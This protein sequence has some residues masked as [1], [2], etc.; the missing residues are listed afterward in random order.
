VNKQGPPYNVA[1]IQR[2]LKGEMSNGDMHR[3]E[4]EALNDPFLQDAIDGLR[5]AYTTHEPAAI[6]PLLQAVET[7]EPAAIKKKNDEAIIPIWRRK[8]V[9]YAVASAIILGS[10]W[11]I[12]NLTQPE[13]AITSVSKKV[14]PEMPTATADSAVAARPV[15]TQVPPLKKAEP[16]QVLTDANHNE[17]KPVTPKPPSFAL[18]RD[19]TKTTTTLSK[20]E[21][22]KEEAAA[23]YK[24][25]TDQALARKAET[26]A[27]PPAVSEKKS[28]PFSSV[29]TLQQKAEVALQDT[30]SKQSGTVISGKVVDPEKYPLE[31]VTLQVKGSS[32]GVVSDELGRFQM[33][34][35]DS[36]VTL[37]ASG[38]GYKTKEFKARRG[39]NKLEFELEPSKSSLSEAVVSDYSM[40]KS[41]S[42]TSNKI[43]LEIDTSEAA[44]SG[45]WKNFEN[46]VSQNKQVKS[47]GKQ[48]IAVILSFEVNEKGNPAEFDI[49]E[50]AG[51]LFDSEAIR[52]LKTGPLWINKTRGNS[53]MVKITILF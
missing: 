30:A 48:P 5:Q 16:Q 47:S 19:E 33:T 3:L 6:D 25:E 7:Y 29:A 12:F 45:G 26:K 32:N 23:N 8:M 51:A 31:N 39:S 38:P 15:E 27:V 34:V 50:S 13:S 53:A 28:Y 24:V 44:P 17:K 9:Q 46:Y 37:V 43:S 21:S 35:P 42:A 11:Y 36:T 22:Q 14:S 4:M 41:R 18:P 10:G 1:D 2:Y 49:I 40:R 52:L 20:A